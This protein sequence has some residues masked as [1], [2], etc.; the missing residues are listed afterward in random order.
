MASRL[1]ITIWS[2]NAFLSPQNQRSQKHMLHKSITEAAMTKFLILPAMFLLACSNSPS[3]TYSLAKVAAQ[4]SSTNVVSKFTALLDQDKSIKKRQTSWRISTSSLLLPLV[5]TMTERKTGC[6]A[7]PNCTRMPLSFQSQS[8]EH[9]RPNKWCK[10]EPKVLPSSWWFT[11]R[12]P[13]SSMRIERVSRFPP[14]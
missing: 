9:Q 3:S 10:M 5:P 1:C 12:K 4:E 6:I 11:W 7:F 2:A 8:L 14:G 13:E